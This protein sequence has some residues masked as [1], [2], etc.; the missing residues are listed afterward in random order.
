M[1]LCGGEIVK[2]IRNGLYKAEDRSG[3]GKWK[4]YFQNESNYKLADVAIAN[5]NK[6][7]DTR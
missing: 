4:N 1:V 3:K 2:S 6:S 7:V 5:Y